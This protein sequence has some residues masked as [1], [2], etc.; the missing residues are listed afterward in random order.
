MNILPVMFAGYINER[1][2]I[3][4]HPLWHLAREV[5]TQGVRISH[6]STNTGHT[7]RTKRFNDHKSTGPSNF[8]L[9]YEEDAF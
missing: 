3:K 6:W 2:K 1:N 5:K 4:T 9:G 8:Q 7:S